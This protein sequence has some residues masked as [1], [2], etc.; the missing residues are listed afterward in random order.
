M[1]PPSETPDRREVL[2]QA[3][4]AL[5]EMQAK[6]DVL[7][8]ARTEPIAVI[9]IG[10]RFPGGANSPA[11]YWTLLRDGV[12][13]VTDVPPGRWDVEALYHPDAEA[14]GKMYVRRGG[15]LEALDLFDPQFFGIS[16]REAASMDPQQRLILEVGWE[17]LEHAGQSPDALANSRTG[18]FLGIGSTDYAHIQAEAGDLAGID[19]YTGT[20]N[21]LCFAAGRL[22]YCLGLQGPSLVVDTACSSSLVAIHLACQSLRLG[23]SALALAGGVHVM[24]TPSVWVFLSKAK[25]LAPDGRCKAFDAAAD[26]YVRGEGCGMVVL[27]RLSDAVR[28]RDRDLA[29]RPDRGA[30]ALGGARPRTLGR[31]AAPGGFGENQHRAPRGSRG[32][33]RAHQDR[34]RPAPRRNPAEPALRPAQP[35]HPRG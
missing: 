1:S 30:G 12:D 32:N 15:F 2:S 34:P 4:Q 21:H 9:G 3:L 22:S 5:D 7:E 25:A 13:A 16:P 18:V 24:L 6:I 11:A 26:G 20:G 33:R 19:A 10:C 17:A 27:K 29:G 14:P 23:E 31:S 8:G 35:A 28:D